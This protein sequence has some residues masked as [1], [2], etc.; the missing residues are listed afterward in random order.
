MVHPTSSGSD[1]RDLTASG[2]PSIDV[3]PYSTEVLT[4]PYPFH[5]ELREPGPV[6][7]LEP[8]AVWASGR[9]EQVR[10]VLTDRQNV[11]SG[12][13]M[14]LIDVRVNYWREPSLLLESDPPEHTLVRKIM[15]R[16]L[17]PPQAFEPMR[18]RFEARQRR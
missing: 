14:G 6:V 13:G 11:I 15:E 16:V 8:H 12:A 10:T 18:K 1:R 2:V 7:W 5:H 3:D 4:D 17:L 9:Y